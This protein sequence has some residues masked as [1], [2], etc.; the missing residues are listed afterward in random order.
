[1]RGVPTSTTTSARCPTRGA[2]LRY[3]TP[4]RMSTRTDARALALASTLH[5]P[6]D[7]VDEVTGDRPN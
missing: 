3:R 2:L 1:M 4:A 5:G 7:F 6:D